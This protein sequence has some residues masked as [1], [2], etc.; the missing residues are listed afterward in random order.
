MLALRSGKAPELPLPE[1][2]NARWRVLVNPELR[3]CCGRGWLCLAAAQPSV[4]TAG[5]CACLVCGTVD[6]LKPRPLR[7]S[8]HSLNCIRLEESD[9]TRSICRAAPSATWRRDSEGP[10]SLVRGSAPLDTHTY[11]IRVRVEIMGSQKCRAVGKSQSLLIYDQSNSLH[12][13]PYWRGVV[14]W[15]PPT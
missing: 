6:S 7:W 5:V 3:A 2:S 10:W 9:H 1:K 13:R 15:G 4:S 14:D 11:Y 12:P 8:V